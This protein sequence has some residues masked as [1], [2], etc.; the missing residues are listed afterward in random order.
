MRS[1][2]FLKV[3]RF[4][5]NRI[6]KNKARYIMLTAVVLLLA[7]FLLV[8]I[9]PGYLTGKRSGSF[10]VQEDTTV[11]EIATSLTKDKFIIDPVGFSFFVRLTGDDN[12]IKS[13]KH[14]FSDVA[15]VFGIIAEIKKGVIGEQVVV[16]IP[17]GFSVKDID[18]RLFEKGLIA[19]KEEF[20]N[21]AKGYEGFLFPDTYFF[22]KGIT[23]QEIVKMM[24]DRFQS[25]LPQDFAM[26]AGG[27][28]FEDVQVITLA[29][30]IEKEVKFDKDRSLAASV[31]INRLKIDMPLQA[32]ST[33]VYILPEHKVWLDESDYKIDSPYNTYLNKGLPP[34]PICNPSIK[35]I[36][37][38]LDAPDSPY[39]YF[40]TKPDGEAVFEKTLDE[41]N[42]DL[43]RYYGQ[44]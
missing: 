34:S 25:V 40:I 31:F 10:T 8:E 27:K 43:A 17:E 4:F 6:S 23:V 14:S 22:Y 15:T 9:F 30:V 5:K 28:G 29:S 7:V 41:H 18:E 37:A 3:A 12:L 42:R 16:T 39:Y 24:N 32:D 2:E 19:K 44:Y 20:L 36:T 33:I 26:K 1:S 11:K 38:V 21:F 13:G 35:S